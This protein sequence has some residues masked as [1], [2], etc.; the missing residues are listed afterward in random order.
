MFRSSQK[1]SAFTLIELL[2]VIAIIAI[3]IGLLLPAVQKIREAAARMKCSNNLKQI[4]LADHNFASANTYLSVGHLGQFTN[5][6]SATLNAGGTFNLFG[7]NIGALT[8]T[9]A[10]SHQWVGSLFILLPYLEQDNL[11]RQ[12][13]VGASTDYL[14][15]DKCRAGL[16]TVAPHTSPYAANGAWAWWQMANLR[17][18]AQARIAG[19]LCPSDNAESRNSNIYVAWYTYLNGQAWN[20]NNAGIREQFLTAASANVGVTTTLARTNYVG[21]GGVFGRTANANDTYQGA[22][23]NRLRISLEQFTSADGTANTFLFGE[24]LGDTE[25]NVNQSSLCWMGAGYLTTRWGLP[26][27]TAP[28]TAAQGYFGW[29]AF[30]SKHS[31]VVLFARADGSVR[32]VR[33]TVGP[34]MVNTAYSG[35]GMNFQF[36]AGWRDGNTVNFTTFADE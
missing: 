14:G 34:N 8:T 26:G 11:F 25:A 13:M 22:K 15:H 17:V 23:V 18:A 10:Q 6:G 9:A 29:N 32:N 36:A 7:T 16:V 35:A 3:L 20:S 4:A 24:T 30:G 19:Y 1:R 12:A 5:N 21:V 28:A 31:G 33:K 2:V 27:T